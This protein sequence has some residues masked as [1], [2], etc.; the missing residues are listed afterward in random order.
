MQNAI[1]IL[2]IAA[3]VS[4]EHAEDDPA[5][6]GFESDPHSKRIVLDLAEWYGRLA[7]LAE[8]REGGQ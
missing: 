1:T 5:P 6:T 3:G 8:L 4:R 2:P 7:R